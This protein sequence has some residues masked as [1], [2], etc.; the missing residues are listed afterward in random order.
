MN[1][2]GKEQKQREWR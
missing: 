1:T 2:N